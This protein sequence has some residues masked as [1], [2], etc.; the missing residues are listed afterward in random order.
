[1]HGAEILM[2]DHRI[3]LMAIGACAASLAYIFLELTRFSWES[4]QGSKIKLKDWKQGG[5]HVYDDEVD[6]GGSINITHKTVYDT[7]LAACLHLIQMR[8][9]DRHFPLFERSDSTT[10]AWLGLLPYALTAIF[11]IPIIGRSFW[12]STLDGI[13][14]P[15]SGKVFRFIILSVIIYIASAAIYSETIEIQH[16]IGAGSKTPLT[17]NWA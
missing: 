12:S 13:W 17:A 7:A 1:M 9:A 14:L 6:L 8:L 2:I 10:A 3:G 16:V 11:G 15:S 4:N 5:L